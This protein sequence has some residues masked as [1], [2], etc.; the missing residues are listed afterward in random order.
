[1][2]RIVVTWLRIGEPIQTDRSTRAVPETFAPRVG[3]ANF[4]RD[5]GDHGSCIIE[6]GVASQVSAGLLAERRDDEAR[7]SSLNVDYRPHG[8]KIDEET[9]VSASVSDADIARRLGAECP[10]DFLNRFRFG[11]RALQ[12]AAVTSKNFAGAVAG[13]ILERPIDHHQGHAR[14]LCI[15]HCHRDS[16][17]FRSEVEGSNPGAVPGV[18]C[19]NFGR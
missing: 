2:A 15:T 5:R 12:E 3:T 8:Q 16:I 10:G 17:V 4:L 11:R 14:E 13:Q 9:A 1:M 7:A 18:A 6:L 19:S